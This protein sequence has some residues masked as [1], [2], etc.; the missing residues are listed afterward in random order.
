[1]WWGWAVLAVLLRIIIYISAGPKGVHVPPPP[2]PPPKLPP[3]IPC[4][5]ENKKQK[6]KKKKQK[7]KQLHAEKRFTNSKFLPTKVFG[8]GLISV[9]RPFNTF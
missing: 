4:P 9:L 5:L 3:I 2:A 7:K 1:M 6:T 8:F